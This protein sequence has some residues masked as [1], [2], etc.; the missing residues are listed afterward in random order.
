MGGP[1]NMD[2]CSSPI[3]W[4]WLPQAHRPTGPQA[5]ESWTTP[6][7]HP[8]HPRPLPLPR[9]DDV[10]GPMPMEL[11]A[12]PLPQPPVQAPSLEPTVPPPEDTVSCWRKRLYQG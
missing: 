2:I 9:D 1:E 7:T 3:F 12:E 10:P 4:V 11:E 6:A 5:R 8:A